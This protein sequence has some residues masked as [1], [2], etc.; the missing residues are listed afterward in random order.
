[1]PKYQIRFCD[2][3]GHGSFK[4]V[5]V[6]SASLWKLRLIVEEKQGKNGTNQQ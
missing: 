3:K 4:Y 2:S 1:M 6:K 5:D